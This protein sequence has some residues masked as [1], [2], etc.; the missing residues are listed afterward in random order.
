MATKQH[1]QHSRMRQQNNCNKTTLYPKRPDLFS[2]SNQ[3]KYSHACTNSKQEFSRKKSG[4][5]EGRIGT[6]ETRGGIVD[7]EKYQSNF[8]TKEILQCLFS[9]LILLESNLPNRDR[10]GGRIYW[11]NCQ[12]A[13]HSPTSPH[14]DPGYCWKSPL[15]TPLWLLT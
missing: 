1:E 6:D 9:R 11:R 13:A 10:E 15:Q 8:S 7:P 5:R 2:A 3:P 12:Q 14:R 4:V